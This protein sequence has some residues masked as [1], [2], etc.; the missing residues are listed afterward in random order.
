M[1]R[2]TYFVFESISFYRVFRH[3]TNATTGGIFTAPSP[4]I[5]RTSETIFEIQTVSDGFV[6]FVELSGKPNFVDLKVTTTSLVRSN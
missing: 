6:K 1:V 4:P 5:S 2:L 3:D